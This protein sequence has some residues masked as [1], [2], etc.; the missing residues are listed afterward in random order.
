M[1][2]WNGFHAGYGV[3]VKRVGNAKG[4]EALSSVE[5][6]E[7]RVDQL[8]LISQAMWEI[9]REHGGVSEEILEAKVEEIDLRDGKRDGK[10][11]KTVDTCPKCS[12][13]IHPRHGKCLY[14]GAVQEHHEVFKRV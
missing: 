11:G 13:K 6:L 1:I 4:A 12:R 8:A 10:V 7:E 3:T 14:C 2:D 5:Q 9:L